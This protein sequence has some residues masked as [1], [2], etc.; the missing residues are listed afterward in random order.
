M[1]EAYRR[2]PRWTIER[3][4]SYAAFKDFSDLEAERAIETLERLARILLSFYKKNIP[5]YENTGDTSGIR[6][7]PEKT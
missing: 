2:F 1:S 4:R 6:K 7:R 3:L 5:R